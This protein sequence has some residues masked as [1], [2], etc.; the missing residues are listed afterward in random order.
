MT[1][2]LLRHAADTWGLLFLGALFLIALWFALDPS[3]R[4]RHHNASE[5]PF[6]DEGPDHD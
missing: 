3:A 6:N 1:Y 5:I 2:D 4:D